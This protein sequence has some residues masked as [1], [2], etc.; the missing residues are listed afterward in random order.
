M[1]RDAPRGGQ[2]WRVP[3]GLL[4]ARCHFPRRLQVAWLSALSKPEAKGLLLPPRP[5][6]TSR[7]AQPAAN[8]KFLDETESK[9]VFSR[10]LPDEGCSPGSLLGVTEH[11]VRR[12]D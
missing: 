4:S 5:A 7:E 6:L 1:V 3:R 2:H 11:I 9:A 10:P 8:S 12:L